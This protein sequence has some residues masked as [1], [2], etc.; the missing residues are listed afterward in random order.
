MKSAGQVLNL[1]LFHWDERT[2]YRSWVSCWTSSCQCLLALSSALYIPLMCWI[3]FFLS[4]PCDRDTACVMSP[5]ILEMSLDFVSR[6]WKR[7]RKESCVLKCQINTL[8]RE[9]KIPK[10]PY[11]IQSVWQETSIV[12]V[13][14]DAE[15]LSLQNFRKTHEYLLLLS[16]QKS[17]YLWPKTRQAN[18]K[19][20]GYILAC[21][22]NWCILIT[23]KILSKNSNLP[24]LKSLKLFNIVKSYCLSGQTS[25][26]WP[27]QLI[28]LPALKHAVCASG[29]WFLWRSL[30]CKLTERTS[31]STTSYLNLHYTK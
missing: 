30:K 7:L 18:Q 14:A 1:L 8:K 3:T 24:L 17:Y 26:S 20:N 21:F 2:T 31:S 29:I 28:R 23:T 25:L 5:A 11:K 4:I 19:I 12:L 9:G 16:L 22:T 15:Q 27:S 13:T 6:R 10:P